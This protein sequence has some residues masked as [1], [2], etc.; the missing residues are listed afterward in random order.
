MNSKLDVLNNMQRESQSVYTNPDLIPSPEFAQKHL[1]SFQHIL[2]ARRSIRVYTGEAIPES[3]MREI[4]H[5]ATLAPSSSNLQVYEMYWVRDPQ[6]KNHVA[7]ACLA[8]PAAKTAGELVVIVS[9]PDKAEKNRKMLLQIMT[10]DGKKL[11]ES[12]KYYYEKLI[13]FAMKTDALGVWNLIRRAL[14]F[15]M[16][17]KRATVRSPVSAADHRIYGHTQA[18]LTAQTLMLSF[19]AHGYDTCPIGGMDSVR[20]HKIL[21]LPNGAEVAMVVSAGTRKPEGLYGERI[22][23]PDSELIKEV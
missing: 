3:V 6:K 20:I 16:G 21:A 2:N 10:K 7:D 15:F 17:L 19:A 14:F 4:L 13:P 11:P 5:E 18:A 1:K 23:L 9:R 8:Q 12:V 22:R